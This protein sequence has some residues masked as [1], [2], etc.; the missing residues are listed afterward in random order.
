MKKTTAFSANDW[1]KMLQEWVDSGLSGAKWC[2]ENNTMDRVER[3]K[4]RRTHPPM[5]SFFWLK[6]GPSG[7]KVDCK[8]ITGF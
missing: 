1:A 4:F 3:T 5:R 8:S 6:N 2:R 7:L